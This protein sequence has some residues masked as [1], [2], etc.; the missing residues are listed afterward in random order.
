VFLPKDKL[1]VADGLR[2]LNGHQMTSQ[3]EDF[4]PWQQR[5]LAAAGWLVVLGIVL[6]LIRVGKDLF[7]PLVIALIGVYLM[8]VL[9]RW[10]S[11]LR[12]RGVGLPS[13][14]SLMLAFLA[15]IGL[16]FLLFSIIADNAMQVVEI[17]PRYQGRLLEL[18]MDIFARLGVEQPPALR[19]FVRDVDLPGIL[20]LVATNLAALLKTTTLIVIFGIFILIESR[21]IPSKIQALFPD[22]ARRQRVEE[23]LSRIDRDVQTYFGVKTLVSLVTALLSYAVMRWVG[24]DFAEFWAL[25]VFILNYIPTIGSLFATILPSLLALFQ[26]E[27]LGPVLILFIGITVIQQALGNFI[28]PNLMGL[29]LNLSPLVVVMSLILWGMLWGV[30][31]MFLCVPITVIAVIIMAN[32]PSTRWVS[33]LLSK[34]GQLRI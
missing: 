2:K 33:I 31:G 22:P 4:Q 29:T 26:F 34:A 15:V 8:K 21:Q 5:G 30:V 9:E 20:T 32:F 1:D 16:S 18:Q 6:V 12:I 3:T 14:V 27:S 11:G 24:L 23:M 10:I 17:A 25:L 7:I 13:P 28:E 19:E